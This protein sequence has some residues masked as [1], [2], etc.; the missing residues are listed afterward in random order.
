MDHWGGRNGGTF[1]LVVVSLGCCGVCK[2][3]L[4][5][6]FGFDFGSRKNELS[7]EGFGIDGDVVPAVSRF[8]FH[9][10]AFRYRGVEFAL[11]LG[12]ALGLEGFE[13]AQ[14]LIERA[15][16]PLFVQGQVDEGFRIVAEDARGSEGGVD[17]DVF[18]IDFAS[19]FGMA[20]GEHGV[21][22]RA[23]PVQAPLGV[24]KGLGVLLFERRFGGEA[25]E[26]A[27]AEEV[28]FGP[29]PRKA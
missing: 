25:L 12:F 23:G 11:S 4:A 29:C 15:V 20:E 21:F 22:E 1:E 19:F 2:T 18:R 24:A 10:I 27:F 28:V 17:L 7:G 3:E 26:E 13:F 5:A 14:G 16:Q 6:R 9:E 8:H